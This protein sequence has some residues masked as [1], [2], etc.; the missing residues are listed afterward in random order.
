MRRLS[1]RQAPRRVRKAQ[2][3]NVAIVPAS[4]L[5]YKQQYQAIANGLRPGQMLIIL[6]KS[7]SPQRRALESAAAILKANGH[8]VAVRH[9]KI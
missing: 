3:D 6:P 5:P 2:F 4:L 8:A 1:F 7:N 9:A